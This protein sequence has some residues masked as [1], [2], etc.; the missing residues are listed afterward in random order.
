MKNL[1]ISI[2]GILA[3]VTLGSGMVFA[4]S[5]NLRQSIVPLQCYLEAVNAGNGS[6]IYITPENCNNN[7]VQ[8]NS[9]N[10]INKSEE[11]NSTTSQPIIQKNEE[12]L[13]YIPTSDNYPSNDL[14]KDDTISLINS[15]KKDNL[16]TTVST[17]IV[18]SAI[19]WSLYRFFGLNR[20]K[21]K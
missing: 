18:S 2:F 16:T 21:I 7:S 15:I 14:K 6:H 11:F 13:T 10:P 4:E 8:P 9:P 20:I 3:I 1:L 19:I 12:N 5:I 17:I